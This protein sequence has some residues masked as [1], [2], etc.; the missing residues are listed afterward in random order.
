LTGESEAT[1]R[2]TIVL[3]CEARNT[4]LPSSCTKCIQETHNGNVWGGGGSRLSIRLLVLL[5]SEVIG[6]ILISYVKGLEQGG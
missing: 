5:I 2:K 1:L 6:R 3:Q 4:V